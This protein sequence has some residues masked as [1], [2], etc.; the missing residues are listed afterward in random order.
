MAGSIPISMIWTI[1]LLAFQQS[2]FEICCEARG[3][4]KN[5]PASPSQHYFLTGKREFSGPKD[6]LISEPLQVFLAAPDLVRVI[7][8]TAKGNQ[9][10]LL[11]PVK[12]GWQKY[13]SGTELISI[14]NP[15]DLQKKTT[16]R[17]LCLRFPWGWKILSDGSASA[18][19]NKE[20]SV[21]LDSNHRPETLQWG[22]E[23]TVSLKDW[24]K[25]KDGRWFPHQWNWKQEER[26]QIE[27]FYLVEPDVLWL[28]SGFKPPNSKVPTWKVVR[29]TKEG[30]WHGAIDRISLVM[31]S[32][33]HTQKSDWDSLT[34]PRPPGDAWMIYKKGQAP[35]F[36]WVPILEEKH[37]P[38]AVSKFGKSTKQLHLRWTTYSEAA[39][40]DAWARLSEAAKKNQMIPTGGLWLAQPSEVTPYKEYFLPVLKKTL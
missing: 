26:Q 9:V 31:K 39:P 10:Q 32:T 5:P 29:Q 19:S 24:R 27:K 8:T 16:C 38:P 37:W 36:V 35:L 23:F 1:F 40:E 33:L 11:H 7:H 22:D 4:K 20:I 30:P 21:R 28:D 18:I 15:R 14:K 25:R 34:I 6:E 17:W 13:P 2:P 3:F 12:K